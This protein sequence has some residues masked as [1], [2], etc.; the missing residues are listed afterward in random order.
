M[1]RNC[2]SLPQNENPGLEFNN[3]RGFKLGWV[4]VCFDVCR[5]CIGRCTLCDI[6][7]ILVVILPISFD[8][9]N[10][11]GVRTLFFA[12][13]ISNTLFMTDDKVNKNRP[14]YNII[15]VT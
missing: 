3:L 9:I 1:S 6:E 13:S 11:Y 2:F 10:N 4:F 8:S 14:L 7:N 12:K 15:L 5:N